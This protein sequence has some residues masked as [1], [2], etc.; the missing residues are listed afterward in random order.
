MAAPNPRS[1]SRRRFLMAGA[2][3]GLG[4][5][6]LGDLTSR[7]IQI[8]RHELTLPTWDA[9]G[10]RIA[11][12]ADIHLR[13]Q[14][15]AERA[16]TAHMMAVAEKPDLILNVGDYVN[17][18]ER[19]NQQFL[20]HALEPLHD[21]K[22]PCFGIMGNHDYGTSVP[23]V[24]AQ[25]VQKSPMRIL[26]NEVVDVQG[27]S[28]AGID[29]CLQGRPNWNVLRSPSVSH[30]FLSLVHEPD[31]ADRNP[32]NVSLQLSGHSHGGQ[33]CLPGGIPLVTP[34]GGR[35]YVAG[36]YPDAEVPIYVSRG[37]GTGGP[38]W[39]LFCPPELSILTL[40]GA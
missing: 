12:I 7:D 10:M 28:I 24:V 1:L 22:C 3:A 27:I 37:I 23:G 34:F 6:A 8:E 19:P 14:E 29:D 17:Q 21:A 31:F 26:V 15:A 16:R 18:F 25:D 40:R 2:S 30:S 36:F 11:V 13:D 5:A 38:K 33:I 39:R 9:Q 32:S 4:I 35:K 20:A